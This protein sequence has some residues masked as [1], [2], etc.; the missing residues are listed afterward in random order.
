MMEINIGSLEF[1]NEI[2]IG[3]LQLDVKN[4]YPELEKVTV[5]SRVE[6]QIVKPTKYG[7]SEITVKP[8]E[9]KLQD[10]T[11]TDDG[12]YSADSEYDGLR[13]VIVNTD[14]TI[15][16][17]YINTKIK[18]RP[19]GGF[20][21]FIKKLPKLDINEATSLANL[22]DGFLGLKEAP[23][24]DT[25]HIQ[26]MYK[27]Y[28]QCR[29]LE[30]TV[31]LDCSSCITMEN[32]FNECYKIKKVILK[33][34]NKVTNF[35]YAFRDCRELELIEGLD[36]SNSTKF[37]QMFSSCETLKKLPYLDTSNGEN[38]SMTFNGI[39]V[40]DM[41]LLEGK[42]AIY[43]VRTFGSMGN[44]KKFPGMHD[45][46]KAYDITKT[47]NF[48]DYTFDL[49]ASPN[50]THDSLISILNNLYD[51]KSKGCKTQ[52]VSI[53]SKNIAKLTAEEIKVATEKG[54]TVS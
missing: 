15:V 10:K 37:N 24:L 11:I 12:I 21:S 19:A 29:E 53:G 17:K 47:A 6:E 2:E 34:T 4:V 16:S 35:V 31:S 44:L 48:S 42:S 45:L 43:I 28:N 51:I 22:C 33:N 14:D 40:E 52:R 9:I 41:Q 18:D 32:I 39:M 50:L 20:K 30:G 54:W 46:G 25:L 3:D 26:N 36:T 38:F 8:M 5:Q 23:T 13:T 27:M 1:Y 49:S 7:F